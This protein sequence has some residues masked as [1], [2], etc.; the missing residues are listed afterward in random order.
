MVSFVCALIG[1]CARLVSSLAI[2]S[3]TNCYSGAFIISLHGCNGRGAEQGYEKNYTDP[4]LVAIPDSF[5]YVLPYDGSCDDLYTYYDTVNAGVNT[6]KS[7]IED[8]AEACPSSKIIIVGYSEGAHVTLNTLGGNQTDGTSPLGL[9]YG[10]QIVSILTFGDPSRAMAQSYNRGTNKA[11]SGVFARGASSLP[12]LGF[13]AARLLSYCDLGD[14]FCAPNTI[15][16]VDDVHGSYFTGAHY[17]NEAVSI[18]VEQFYKP[19]G[20][21]E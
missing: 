19:L 1:L 14:I 5:R 4:L 20:R 7:A 16:V 3:R 13:Y 15:G 17:V 8:Y 6:L 18:A 12:N 10:T 9:S 2:D 21:H 11:V